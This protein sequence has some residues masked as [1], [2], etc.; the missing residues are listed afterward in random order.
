MTGMSFRS[1]RPRQML[2][3]VTVEMKTPR[4]GNGQPYDRMGHY[5]D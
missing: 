5:Y 1:L 2:P 3:R 4:G